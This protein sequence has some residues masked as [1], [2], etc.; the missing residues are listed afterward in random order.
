M[1][2]SSSVSSELFLFGSPSKERKIREK[3]ITKREHFYKKNIWHKHTRM[4]SKHARIYHESNAQ[5]NELHVRAVRVVQS[6]DVGGTRRRREMVS[7]TL[8]MFRFSKISSPK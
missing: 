6:V 4:E 2:F 5:R 7:E 8:F 1:T 3:I